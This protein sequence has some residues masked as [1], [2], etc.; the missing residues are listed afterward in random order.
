MDISDGIRMFKP[1]TL[2]DAI[3]FVR[4]KD[5]QL[6]RQRRF[7][8]PAPPVRAPLALPPTNRAAPIAP[9]SPARRLS[10]DEMH[11]RRLQGLCFNCNERFTAGHRC[12]GLRILMLE[13]HD[14]GDNVIRNDVTEEQH[15]E[16]NHEELIEPEITLHA[17]TGWIAPKTMRVAARIG[18]NNVITLIDSG[19]THNFI[20]ER[21]ANFL[22]LPMVPTIAFTVR[23]AN[24]EN[25]RCQG[26]STRYQ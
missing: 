26:G 13:G 7:I 11:R 4:M 5:D 21:M 20:S 23:V 22:W 1:Q 2:K 15:A 9:I 12:Q 17:L 6:E 24:R 14:D 10:W 3:S 8:R 25:L 16:E 19:S 18:S